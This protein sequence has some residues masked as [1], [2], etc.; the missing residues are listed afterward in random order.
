MPNTTKKLIK[1]STKNINENPYPK[2]ITPHQKAYTN[3]KWLHEGIH[4]YYNQ[5]NLKKI[6]KKITNWENN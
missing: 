3:F 2:Y 6:I 5:L 4:T 1:Y